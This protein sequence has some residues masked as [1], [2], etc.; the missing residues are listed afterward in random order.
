MQ[1]APFLRI[2]TRG[3]L[4]ALKQAELTRDLLV[5]AH[6]V[7]PEEIE[8]RVISTGGDRIQDRPLS[9]VGGKGLFSKEIETAL[10]AGEIDLGVHS[11]KDMA[12]DLP[13]GLVLAAYLEREDIRDAFI[14]L[15]YPDLDA[16][17][18]GAV[19]GTSSIRRASQMLRYRPDLKVVE[20]RGNVLTRLGKLEAGVADAT[21]L[22]VAGLNR[23]G[24]AERITSVIDP[25]EFL[26]APAQGA[27]GIEI[28]ASDTRVAELVAPLNHA[29]TST[30]VLAERGLLAT[31]DGSCRTPIGAFTELHV[32]GCTLTGEILSADG[33][34]RYRAER[35]GAI[36]DAARIGLDLGA[37]LRAEAGPAFAEMFKT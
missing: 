32:N 17:P 25:R 10:S 8:I 35:S 2:G 3:S 11:A 26:P 31:L 12:S 37:E 13:E 1:S 14:S 30:A 7:A 22:A 19:L 9:E 15:K 24:M 4:L 21:L 29:D 23:L 36:A 34:V 27:I 28:R 20:F 5:A 6:G 18:E 16:L 33:S